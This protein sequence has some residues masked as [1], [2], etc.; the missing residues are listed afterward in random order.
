MDVTERNLRN[1]AKMTEL[2][3]ADGANV[4]LLVA[5]EVL[6]LDSLHYGYWDDK[7]ELSLGSLRKA[8][9]RHTE[10]MIGAIPPGV[11]SILDVGCGIGDNALAFTRAGYRVTAIS[12]D[13]NHGQYVESL[14]VGVE[15]V[16]CGLG[17]FESTETFDLIFLSESQ[18]YF[19]PE[20]TFRTCN[21]NLKKPGYL[22]ISDMFNATPAIRR[23]G[24]THTEEQYVD[25]A[26]QFGLRLI[27]STD[28]TAN[29]LPTLE[30]AHSVFSQNALP[31]LG[32]ADRYA[33]KIA[34]VKHWLIRVFFH[35]QIRKIR[36][37]LEHYEE[38][39]SPDYFAKEMRYVRLLFK[40]E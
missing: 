28:V 29:V 19:D 36:K 18:T 10:E 6:K 24:V 20:I 40:L 3:D 26:R 15:F 8:Q 32:I 16:N 30:L 25:Q 7:A 34:P 33:R 11:T 17:E 39:L 13:R 22:L 38:R 27:D 1:T 14:G 12:P 21:K 23:N 31:A 9:S 2:L 4:E 5:T 35:R 37:V